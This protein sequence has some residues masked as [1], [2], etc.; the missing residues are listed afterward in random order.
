MQP[1]PVDP[2]TPLSVTL[3]AEQW[4]VV[5]HAMREVSMPLRISQPVLASIGEQLEQA[6][7]EAEQPPQM[8]DLK[9]ANGHAADPDVA[10]PSE[11][12]TA[13]PPP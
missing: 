13:H 6:T 12:P 11:Q 5:I 4:N 2:A 1:R 10:L 7:L 3:Q 8:P 9:R